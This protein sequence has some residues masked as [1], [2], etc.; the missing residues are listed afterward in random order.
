MAV[1]DVRGGSGHKNAVGAGVDKNVK[2]PTWQMDG[3]RTV[4]CEQAGGD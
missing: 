2:G 3:N 4:G 1:K